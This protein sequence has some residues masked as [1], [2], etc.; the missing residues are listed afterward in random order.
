[1]SDRKNKSDIMKE[2]LGQE[3]GW[4]IGENWD[5]SKI[6]ESSHLLSPNSVGQEA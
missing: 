3:K 2:L 6:N 4:T 1:M 5:Y